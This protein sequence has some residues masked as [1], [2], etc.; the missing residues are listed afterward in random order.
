MAI[1]RLS[2]GERK[3][4]SIFFTCVL[5]AF[6]AWMLFSLSLKYDYRVKTLVTFKNLPVNKAFYPLQSDTVLITVQGTGWQLLFNKLS[7]SVNE[8]KVDLTPLE[9]RNFISFNNQIR[10]INQ[11]FSSN[12]TIL[13][14][15][16]DTLFFDFTTRKVKRVP[17]KL[18]SDINFKKQFGQSKAIVLKPAFV[19]ITGPTDMLQKIDYWE[20]DTLKRKNVEKPFSSRVYLKQSSE[21]NISIFPNAVEVYFP[22]EELTEKI[23][24]VPIKITNNPNYYS[25]KM[26]PNTVTARVMVSLSD[27]A[28]VNDE[29]ITAS[30]DLA[31]WKA[32]ANKLPI[33]LNNQNPFVK[34]QQIYPQQVDFMIVK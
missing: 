22:V 33:T 21:A 32:G 25:V 9:R 18:A 12:Q 19:T 10:E 8:I 26:I 20:T 4:L 1:I 24:H 14:V 3:R 11:Q 23:L 5:L 13:S 30:A 15:Q 7:P 16:P 34:V 29:N 31:L 17:V 2:A 27:Y 6:T 28:N